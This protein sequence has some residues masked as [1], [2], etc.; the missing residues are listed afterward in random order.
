MPALLGFGGN[1]I[2]D[3]A[4][5]SNVGRV[6]EPIPFGALGPASEL[7]FSPPCR[8]PLGLGMGAATYEGR[9]FL[10]FR[11]RHAQW[12]AEA[13][14]RFADAYVDLLERTTTESPDATAPDEHGWHPCELTTAASTGRQ[15]ASGR[16]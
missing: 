5:L 1:R 2:V 9:M 13:A 8:M 3:T 16:Q 7:W 4:V 10:M 15:P 12:S 14:A 11:Y 6:R